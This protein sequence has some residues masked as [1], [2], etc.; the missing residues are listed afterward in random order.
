MNQ[1]YYLVFDIE[2]IPLPWETFS[3]SQQEYLLRYAESE[4]DIEKKKSELAL[5]PLTA[6]VICLGLQLMQSTDSGNF[7]LLKRAA[8]S[9]TPNVTDDTIH[10]EVLPD[11][12]KCHIVT[13]KKLLENSLSI[14]KAFSLASS[15]V[16]SS[17][18][19]TTIILSFG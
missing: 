18:A 8:Y 14:L 9:V 3:E 13:E 6:Q 10:D 12:V 17:Q 16:P 1:E 15:F 11:K 4:A 7:E 2:T 5:T 19:K